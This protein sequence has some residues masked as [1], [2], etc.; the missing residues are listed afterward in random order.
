VVVIGAG[1]AGLAAANLLTRNGFAVAIFEAGNK[2]GGCCAT[3]TVEGYTFHDGAV[4]LALLGILD[5]AFAKLD[6]NRIERLPLRKITVKSSATLPDKSVVTLGEGLELT[7]AGRAV[8]RERVRNELRRML[9]KWMPVLRFVSEEF[10]LRPFSA[11]RLLRKG[12][13]HLPKLRGNA[14]SEFNRLFSDQAVKSALSGAL[15]Y[16]GVPAEEMPVSAILG[17]AAEIGEGFYLPEGGMGRIS[18]V[19]NCALQARGVAVCLNFESRQDP[20]QEPPCLR[21]RGRRPAGGRSRRDLDG[22]RDADVRHAPR[23]GIPAR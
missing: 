10:V 14:A 17:L 3:T 23:C 5:H 8:D 11:W 6:L 16:H 18:Q 22:Q 19:L 15:L 21:R 12:W 9:E 13:R 7:V 20:R 1:V 4:Y 2:V